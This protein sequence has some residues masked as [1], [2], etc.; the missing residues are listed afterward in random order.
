MPTPASQP[1]L[2]AL[3]S[4]VP[5][6]SVLLRLSLGSSSRDDVLLCSNSFERYFH[7]GFLPSALFVRQTP[8]PAPTAIHRRQLPWSSSSSRPCPLPQ[9]GSITVCAIRP[10]KSGV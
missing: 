2:Q 4:P 9:F 10:L 8:P 6:H 3:A 5:T 1:E 7:C